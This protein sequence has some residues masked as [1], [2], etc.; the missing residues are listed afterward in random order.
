MRLLE[1]DEVER[2]HV[3]HLALDAGVVALDGQ[4]DAR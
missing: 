4:H 2:G 1:V 3:L